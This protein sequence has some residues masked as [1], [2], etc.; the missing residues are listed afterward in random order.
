MA[1]AWITSPTPEALVPAGQ[2]PRKIR[3]ALTAF[4][5]AQWKFQVGLRVAKFAH[6][7]LRIVK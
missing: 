4:G 1:A 5:F 6:Q 2:R 7:S 3:A